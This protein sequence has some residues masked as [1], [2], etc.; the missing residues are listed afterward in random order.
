MGALTV[1]VESVCSSINQIFS[2]DRNFK[3]KLHDML[4]LGSELLIH[5]LSPIV[6]TVAIFCCKLGNKLL[7]LSRDSWKRS[8]H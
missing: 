3:F 4:A 8:L 6:L 1:R 5:K 2:I 7:S